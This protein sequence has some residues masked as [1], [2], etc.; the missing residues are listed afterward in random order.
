MFSVKVDGSDAV[1]V[2]LEHLA[3][4]N[5]KLSG[6]QIAYELQNQLNARFGTTQNLIFLVVVSPERSKLA[7]R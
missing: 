7:N 4:K 5:V 1:N 3:G 6:T 2:G